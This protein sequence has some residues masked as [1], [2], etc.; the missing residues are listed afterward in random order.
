MR[1]LGIDASG[2]VLDIAVVQDGKILSQSKS[3]G[4]RDHS[5]NIALKVQETMQSS[6]LTFVDLDCFVAVNSP[7]SYTGLR[8]GAAIAK[9]LAFGVNKPVYGVDS[10][11]DWDKIEKFNELKLEYINDK[12]G[13]EPKARL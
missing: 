4:K 2:D 7:G 5:K 9:G 10:K 11:T 13:V 6:G 12:W 1:F 3:E 8:I